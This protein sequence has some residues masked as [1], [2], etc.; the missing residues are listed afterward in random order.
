MFTANQ[1]KEVQL[2][3]INTYKDQFE[4]AYLFDTPVLYSS[5]PIPREDVP[6]GWF[7]YDLRG[8]DRTVWWTRQTKVT[9][10]RSS[11]LCR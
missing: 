2:L 5:Q 10:A 8:T 7:C 9:P 1:M 3:Q 11:P 6:Q 4:K